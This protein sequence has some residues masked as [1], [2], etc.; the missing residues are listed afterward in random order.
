MIRAR[1]GSRGSRRRRPRPRARRW[2]PST[3]R[4][5]LTASRL[6]CRGRCR[7]PSRLNARRCSSRHPDRRGGSGTWDVRVGREPLL[8][9]DVP[10]PR[11]PRRRAGRRGS[12]SRWVRVGGAAALIEADE[13]GD[14]GAHRLDRPS[15]PEA[16]SSVYAFRARFTRLRP[17]VRRPRT[18]RPRARGASRAAH[19]GLV[20]CRPGS[21]TTSPVFGRVDTVTSTPA[22]FASM[23][24]CCVVFTAA[25][26][27][28]RRTST[29]NSRYQ[30]Q[31]AATIERDDVRLLATPGQVERAL[32]IRKTLTGWSSRRCPASPAFRAGWQ[33]AV[34]V[35]DR[36]R[37]WKRRTTKR[38]TEMQTCYEDPTIARDALFAPDPVAERDGGEARRRSRR[39]SP[40]QVPLRSD[41]TRLVLPHT[42]P[43]GFL[44]VVRVGADAA[45]AGAF[46]L[47][48]PG[49]V[50][51]PHAQI[52]SLPL[53]PLSYGA[54]CVEYARAGYAA[55]SASCSSRM[56][57]TS[58]RDDGRVELGAGEAHELV[59]RLLVG[60]RR[61]ARAFRTPSRR[62]RCTHG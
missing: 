39:C 25:G 52:R 20:A 31:M 42:L 29:A 56:R 60:E 19:A 4:V 62:T 40:P 27:P 61:T 5:V 17:L 49:G 34:Q 41:A 26:S 57:A 48:A 14:R 8:R 43:H 30:R 59:Q 3:Q 1:P 38:R 15:P 51:P 44:G 36:R 23:S 46:H 54:C 32:G 24:I 50:E 6:R 47:T 35:S 13:R 11:R 22:A 53:Y 2:R 21:R 10:R 28:H 12:S 33:Q 18:P 45:F 7:D 9:Y 58:T 37:S 16:T 55:R